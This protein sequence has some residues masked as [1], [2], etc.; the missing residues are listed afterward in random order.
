MAEPFTAYVAC[1]SC[2]LYACHQIRTPKPTPTAAELREWEHTVE[3]MEA[4]DF[5][6][7]VTIL[8]EDPPRPVDES[9]FEVVRICE[10]GH[11]WGMG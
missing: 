11:E 3:R 10:C 9:V 6:G 1:P 5:Q 4:C 8:Y 7:R 2:G